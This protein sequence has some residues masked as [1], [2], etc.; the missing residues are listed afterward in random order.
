MGSLKRFA[1]AAPR[2]LMLIAAVAAVAC[3]GSTGTT[4][5]GGPT[6]I[7]QEA[8]SARINGATWTAASATIVASNVSGVI[9]VTGSESGGGSNR[10]ITLVVVTNATGTFLIG[11]PPIVSSGA[12]ILLTQGTAQW[13]ADTNR[14]S[15]TITLTSLTADRVTGTFEFEGQA[16]PTSSATGS[17][18]VTGGTFTADF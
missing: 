18:S 10:A 9:T 12:S 4:G 8:M 2:Q 6:P 17:R 7:N 13:T 15:G 3:G 5:G 11:Q 16:V 14:G 1:L